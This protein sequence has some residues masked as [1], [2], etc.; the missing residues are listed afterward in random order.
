MIFIN[1]GVPSTTI[2]DSILYYENYLKKFNP[3]ST[4]IFTGWNDILNSIRSNF[5]NKIIHKLRKY[6]KVFEYFFYNIYFPKV[7]F[8]DLLNFYDER[9][10]DKYYSDLSKFTQN[11]PDNDF[12]ILT[13]P[14]YL[15]LR[16]S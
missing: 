9:V 7:I 6:S 14:T 12:I 1:A 13:L 5:V 16:Y 4:I 10:I 11:H 8:S 2:S 3:R 15:N